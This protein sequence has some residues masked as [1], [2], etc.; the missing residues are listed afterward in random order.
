[1][2]IKCTCINHSSTLAKLS[3]LPL[4]ATDVACCQLCT[5][6]L[7]LDLSVSVFSVKRQCQIWQESGVAG[8][9]T[10]MNIFINHESYYM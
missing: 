8:A 6:K 1:M 10:I 4:A 3:D 5:C 9:V 2:W 7:Q